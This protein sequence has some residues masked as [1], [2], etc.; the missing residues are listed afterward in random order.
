MLWLLLSSLVCCSYSLLAAHA[1]ALVLSVALAFTLSRYSMLA[2]RSSLFA[3]CCLLLVLVARCSLLTARC[4]PLALQAALT[5]QL[6]AVLCSLL[7]C[8]P[9]DPSACISFGA[10]SM[11][12]YVNVSFMLDFLLLARYPARALASYYAF[13]ANLQPFLCSLAA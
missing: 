5:L 6:P 10:C 4:S 3:A 8:P 11:V 7:V 13:L 2:A 9:R 1:L 12:H